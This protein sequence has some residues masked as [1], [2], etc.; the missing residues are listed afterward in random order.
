M[1]DDF[2][3]NPNVILDCAANSGRRCK[4]L[5]HGWLVLLVRHP[6]RIATARCK[7]KFQDFE[8]N[9][10]KLYLGDVLSCPDS[11]EPP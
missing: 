2:S 7:I 9:S 5:S 10:S 3:Y 8:K 11:V 4:S 6:G 1:R